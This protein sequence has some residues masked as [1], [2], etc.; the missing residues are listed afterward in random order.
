[1]HETAFLAGVMRASGPVLTRFLAGFTDETHTVQAPGLP[2]HVAWTLGHCAY[3]MGRLVERL[4]G[5]ALPEAFFVAGDGSQGTADR[6][7]TFSVRLG[8]RPMPN[9][10]FY[11]TLSRGVEAFEAAVEQAAR[12]VLA[13][14]ETD[15]GVE[16]PWGAHARSRR[17]LV[18]RVALH[19]AQHAGQ[20]TDLRRALSMP[21]IA[22]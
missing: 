14:S 15:L 12:S 22:G 21:V 17:D 8:S 16:V 4:G 5:P 19:N 18:V 3:T 6:F 7:D 20:L 9:P 13:L 11:P 1:M 2:N 10:A